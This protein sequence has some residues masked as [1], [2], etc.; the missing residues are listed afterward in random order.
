MDGRAG[1]LQRALEGGDVRG[2]EVRC[3]IVFPFEIVVVGTIGV[4]EGL[5]EVGGDVKRLGVF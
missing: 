2:G 4:A 5:G 3:G 1:G